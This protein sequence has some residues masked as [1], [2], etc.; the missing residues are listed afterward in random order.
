MPIGIIG[1]PRSG[2]HL[3]IR[4]WFPNHGYPG[5]SQWVVDGAKLGHRINFTFNVGALIH[6]EHL[7]DTAAQRGRQEFALSA[8]LFQ[9][10]S[11][12]LG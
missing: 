4:E 11:S 3:N 7:I 9:Q 12:T 10:N 8:R 5:I 2:D 6:T 1:S